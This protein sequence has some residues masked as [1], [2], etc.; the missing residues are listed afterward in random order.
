VVSDDD[1]SEDL[2]VLTDA[3]RCAMTAA[4]DLK[5]DITSA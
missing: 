3:L 2:S 1:L 5:K 4:P